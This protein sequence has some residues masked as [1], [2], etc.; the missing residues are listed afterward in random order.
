LVEAGDGKAEEDVFLVVA[1]LVALAVDAVEDGGV[2]GVGVGLGVEVFDAKA[3]VGGEVGIVAEEGVDFFH[4]ELSFARHVFGAARGVVAD[5]DG[6]VEVAK[7]GF[8]SV[9]EGVAL[10]LGEVEGFVSD[11]EEADK[12]I[13]QD[14]DEEEG[15]DGEDGADFWGHGCLGGWGWLGSFGA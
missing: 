7:N 5:G 8:G 13:S 14:G 12:P 15:R 11:R 2:L 6:G 3:V 4:V 10:V 1:V 9:G